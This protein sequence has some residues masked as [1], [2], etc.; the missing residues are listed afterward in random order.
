MTNK[1]SISDLSLRHIGQVN[2]LAA[3]PQPNPFLAHRIFHST[4]EI[5]KKDTPFQFQQTILRQNSYALD[6]QLG[7]FDGAS[8]STSAIVSPENHPSDSASINTLSVINAAAKS[9]NEEGNQAIKAILPVL[10][11]R[12]T[13]V[14]ILLLL[15][16]LYILKNNHGSATALLESYLSRLDES[17]NP[18]AKDVRYAPGLVAVAVALYNSQ[19]RKAH[20]RALLSAAASHWRSSSKKSSVPPNT[21]L[22]RAAGSALLE[23]GDKE[24][25]KAAVAIF[26][27]LH[28]RNSIDKAAA[29]GLVAATCLTEPSKLES[30]LLKQLTPTSRL[31]AGID[32]V[33]LENAG[34]ARAPESAV[35]TKKRPATT[36]P[37]TEKKKRKLPKSRVPA[38]F[39]EGKVLD[40][41]RW[42]P[43][44]DRA[45]WRPKGKKGKAKAAG[46]TQGGPVDE[47]KPKAESS[48]VVVGQTKK[49]GK[50]KGKGGKW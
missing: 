28:T 49:G 17:K 23:S 4:P 14:G 33:A 24:D 32:A 30:S 29:A 3:S 1:N 46:L 34:V 38:E 31:T 10:E 41:D 21:A 22:L 19:G 13:D 2:S 9:H 8:K 25:A 44:R 45:S 35:L 40:P 39:V 43:L 50:K 37:E 27:D 18:G 20:S 5:P 7:K 26:K 48:K 6:L 15:I 12:P 42:L 16:Q 36:A 11:K 47:E